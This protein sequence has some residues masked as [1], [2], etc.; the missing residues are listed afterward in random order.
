[1]KAMAR[2]KLSRPIFLGWERT[3]LD[4]FLVGIASIIDGLVILLTL[5][6]VASSWQYDI[7]DWSLH[8]YF[9]IKEAKQEAGKEREDALHL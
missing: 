9:E 7:I 8:K 4:W 2:L 1:M 6:H 5:G 3:Y